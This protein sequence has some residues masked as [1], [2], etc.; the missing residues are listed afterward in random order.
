MTRFANLWTVVALFS[1]SL[2]LSAILISAPAL[3]HAGGHHHSTSAAISASHAQIALFKSEV[4]TGRKVAEA[5]AAIFA[6]NGTYGILP[7]D[8]SGG[9]SSCCGV[10]CHGG[11]VLAAA[12]LNLGLPESTAVLV[13]PPERV[14]RSDV[15]F[16]L[17]R[18]PRN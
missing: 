13:R 14:L 6:D 17:K 11:P 10:G 16:G 9:F 7:C 2:L 5:R 8:H 4:Q 15:V 18:P 12:D 3:A 1:A